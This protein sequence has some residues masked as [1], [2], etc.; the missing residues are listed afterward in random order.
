DGPAPRRPAA[1][2]VRATTKPPASG[3][4]AATKPSTRLER[5]L[6]QRAA[7]PELTDQEYDTWENARRHLDPESDVY[8]RA[9]EVRAKWLGHLERLPPGATRGRAH[10]AAGGA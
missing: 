4:R 2:A 8:E 1:R 5:P 3:K 7:P 9:P 10:A 6:W